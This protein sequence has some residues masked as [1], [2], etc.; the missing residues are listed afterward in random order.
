MSWNSLKINKKIKKRASRINLILKRHGCN[1]RNRASKINSKR[2]RKRINNKIINFKRL[3]IFDN[4]NETK[5]N[6]SN[7]II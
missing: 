1:V 3:T 7:I 2:N 6:L 5:T 4:L